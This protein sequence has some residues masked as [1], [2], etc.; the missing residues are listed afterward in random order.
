[1]LD[2]SLLEALAAVIR[3]GSFERAARQLHVTPSAVSQRI[4]LL[5]ERVGTVLVLRGQPCAATPAGRT[6]CQHAEQVA[7]LE[8][9]LPSALPG[10]GPMAARPTLRIAVNADSLAGW[11]I[12]VMAAHPDLLF[13]LVL[14][15]QD[16]SA[17]WLRQGE[18]LA[19]VTSSDRPVAGCDCFALGA[20]RYTAVASPDYMRRHFPDGVT[21]AALADAPCLTFNRKDGL[22]GQW[23]RRLLGRDLDV[24]THWLPSSQA[25]LDAAL[26]GV[27]WGMNIAD[28]A[29]PFLADGRLRPL[30]PGS[31]LDVPL[32]WQR[33]RIARKALAALTATVR[34]VA[35]AHLRAM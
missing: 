23:L 33:S 17:D 10:L 29:A 24:P 7:L 30:V 5:E 12:P 6:L 2:Y 15:D 8:S 19:A 14:D 16:H 26:A 20:L 22:Q 34:Q 35:G 18:V 25:F 27:G 32:Y 28:V 11:F 9:E 21:P 31:D 3:T 1:M 13:D 4:K